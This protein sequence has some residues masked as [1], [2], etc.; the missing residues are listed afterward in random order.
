ML[1][2]SAADM[3]ISG[4]NVNHGHVGSEVIGSFRVGGSQA[5]AVLFP[6]SGWHVPAREVTVRVQKSAHCQRGLLR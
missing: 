6:R 5:G 4:L 3:L 2:G 1:F